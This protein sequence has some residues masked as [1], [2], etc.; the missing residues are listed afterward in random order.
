M[1][2]GSVLFLLFPLAFAY[3][4]LRHRLFDIGFIVRQGL[5]YALARGVVAS[6]LPAA[7][8]VLLADLL[9]HRDQTVGAILSARG[10]PYAVIGVVAFL[11]LRRRETWLEAIDR[12]FFRERYNAQQILREVAE[13]IRH[14]GSLELVGPR[15]VGRIEAALHPEFAALLVREPPDPDYR[16]IASAPAGA[17]PPAISADTKT[18]GLLRLLGKPLHVATADS[19]WLQQLPDAETDAL[20][21]AYIDLLVPISLSAANREALLALGQKRSEEPYGSEDR[22]LLLA[23]ANSLAMLI[24]RPAAAPR[25]SGSSECPRCG[26]CYDSGASRCPLDATPLTHST[27]PRHLPGRRRRPG[28]AESAGFR[29]GEIPGLE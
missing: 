23:I 4:I 12:R 21:R 8:A 17:T 5:Q 10:W 20:R 16:S 13:E 11:A 2:A 3:S 19:G 26:G 25:G 18:I 15:V 6:T 7:A 1:I 28:G 22:E 27:V 24:E 29:P 9:L 14:A